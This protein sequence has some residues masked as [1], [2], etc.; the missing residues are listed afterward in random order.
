MRDLKG[1][2][3]GKYDVAGFL[4]HPAARMSTRVL[5]G[6]IAS[7]GDL[8]FTYGEYHLKDG[9]AVLDGGYYIRIWR[10]ESTSR[11]RVAVDLAIS[12]PAMAKEE[13]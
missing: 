4:V 7:A 13:R 12:V 3:T 5:G 8:G 10:K 2:C 11:W 1:V 9:N 6:G